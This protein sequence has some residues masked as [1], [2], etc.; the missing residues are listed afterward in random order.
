M[1][2]F[3]SKRYPSLGYR[4][5]IAARYRAALNHHPFLLF[6]LPFIL[7]IL[8]GSYFLT[9]ATAV[10]YERH[11]RRVR[12]LSK[13]EALGIGK[14]R[15]KVDINEEY[16]RLAAK[17]SRASRCPPMPTRRGMT[18]SRPRREG[19]GGGGENYTRKKTDSRRCRTWTA[20]RIRGSSG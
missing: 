14:D 2:T 1:P 13:E 11:D 20:G 16:Y 9:P 12:Q 17:V 19:G 4:S 10:R 7:T 6:G 5:T 3:Q 8:A 18:G 15:R